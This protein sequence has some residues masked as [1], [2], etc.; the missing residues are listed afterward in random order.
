MIVFDN[1]T[2]YACAAKSALNS[3]VI[4]AVCLDPCTRYVK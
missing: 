4:F 3:L 1:G 2:R